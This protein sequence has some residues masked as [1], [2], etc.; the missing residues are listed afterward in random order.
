V[1]AIEWLRTLYRCPHP[2]SAQTRDVRRQDRIGPGM[3]GSRLSVF[4][5]GAG[6]P[7]VD[8]G[9][10]ARERNPCV[11]RGICGSIG[12]VWRKGPG[13]IDDRD[14]RHECD[15]SHGNQL[16][17]ETARKGLGPGRQGLRRD[18]RRRLAWRS[19]QGQGQFARHPGGNRVDKGAYLRRQERSLRVDQRDLHLGADYA[20]QH[21]HERAAVQVRCHETV[22]EERDAQPADGGVA[23]QADVVREECALD[24]QPGARN[25]GPVKLRQLAAGEAEQTAVRAEIALRPGRAVFG[26]VGRRR[27][28]DHR[29]AQER[30]RDEAGLDLA[31]G[32]QRE[33][34]AVVEDVDV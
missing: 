16:P 6:S 18:E 1:L 5:P 9:G 21:L 2:R 14:R 23:Q 12:G 31:A 19:P 26:E 7:R 22:R 3:G 24:S 8:G 29:I 10:D 4:G 11:G 28:G 34:I 27:H 33:V 17:V 25:Q 15:Q 13:R 20:G 32:T 30:A